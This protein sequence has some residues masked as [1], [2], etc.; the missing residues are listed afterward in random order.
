[1]KVCTDACVFGAWL[2][3]RT[4]HRFADTARML[5]I[6]TGTGLLSLMVAQQTEGRIDAVEIDADAYGQASQNFSSSPWAE[7]LT[8]VHADIRTWTPPHSYD[9]VFANPPFYEHDLRSPSGARNIA[10]H[11][12]TL[13]LGELVQTAKR[14]LTARGRFAVLLPFRRA[15]VFE[16]LAE[17]NA[18]SLAERVFLRHTPAHKPFRV[19]YLCKMSSGPD[20][21]REPVVNAPLPITPMPRSPLPSEE[22]VIKTEK[23]DYSDAFAD[24]LRD[25][26]LIF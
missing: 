12:G 22:L 14:A 16:K 6:G 23:N 3:V 9:L 2:A 21:S 15:A 13:G 17:E 20:R 5:D 4:T 7:R 24:L 18:F 25:Y 1:M 26:Y 11:S 19:L 8:A 10:M